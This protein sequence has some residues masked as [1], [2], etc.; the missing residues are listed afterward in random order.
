[1]PSII[2]KQNNHHIEINDNDKKIFLFEGEHCLLQADFKFDQTD[3][4]AILSHVTPTE[5]QHEQYTPLLL[6][7]TNAFLSTTPM[8][9]SKLYCFANDATNSAL[10]GS[11]TF[12]SVNLERF[13]LRE[14][15]IYPKN[16]GILP[17]GVTISALDPSQTTGADKEALLHLLHQTYWAD[18][19]KPSYINSALAHSTMVVARNEKNTIIGLVRYISN[20]HIAYISDMAVDSNYRRKNIATGL[21]SSALEIIDRSHEFSAL[22]SA[23][24]GDGKEASEK[25]YGS[26]FGFVDYDKQ[27]EHTAQFSYVKKNAELTASVTANSIFKTKP[28]PIQ[29]TR[30][31]EKHQPNRK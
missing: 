23:R 20:N 22:I 18:N 16:P 27:H 17:E 15:T 28:K 26:K 24:E 25:L 9:C 3:N 2:F 30:P 21:L 10:N 14:K 12:R 31:I 6:E 1:M 8:P 19:A 29:P 7:M 4:A 13:M 11:D 5:K